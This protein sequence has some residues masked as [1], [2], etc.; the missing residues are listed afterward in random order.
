LA[1]RGGFG[2][3]LGQSWFPYAQVGLTVFDE[4]LYVEYD[5]TW[6]WGFGVQPTLHGGVAWAA[7]DSVLLSAGTS[8]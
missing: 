8:A 1:L 3:Q 5:D 6:W 7:A 4:F 2:W